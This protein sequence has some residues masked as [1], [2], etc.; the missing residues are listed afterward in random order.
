[1]AIMP[2]AMLVGTQL[3]MR[4]KLPFVLIVAFC[5]GVLVTYAEPAIA[6][7]RWGTAAAQCGYVRF[8]ERGGC[9]ETAAAVR[10]MILQLC[11]H[12]P[13]LAAACKLP[14]VWERGVTAFAH[15]AQRARLHRRGHVLGA[16]QGVPPALQHVCVKVQ[17]VRLAQTYKQ[18]LR[19]C[20]HMFCCCAGPWRL[21][22]TPVQLLTSTLL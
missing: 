8:A 5:L 14:S 6:A 12:K 22:L 4:L 1:M 16:V 21:L 19:R 15:A 17:H 13:A 10:A 20:A 3:P 7:I 2:M 18:H 9:L 11:A